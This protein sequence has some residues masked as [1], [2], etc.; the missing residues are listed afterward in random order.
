MNTNFKKNQN[1]LHH[2]K[3]WRLF[4]A[5]GGG[6]GFVPKAAGTAGTLLAFPLYYATAP[7]VS[8]PILIIIAAAGFLVGIPLCTHANKTTNTHDDRAIV[9]DEIAAFYIV[10]I[11]AGSE[12]TQ[13][14]AAFALFRFFDIAKPYPIS[15]I[16]KNIKSG[17]GIMADDLAAAAATIATLHLLMHFSF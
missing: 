11:Y 8:T 15:W 10:L 9:W 13:Q 6:V 4:L 2:L 14:L 1:R 16:D 7:F 3:D 12:W 17:A 5:Y